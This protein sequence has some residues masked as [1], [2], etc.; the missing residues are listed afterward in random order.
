MII[1]RKLFVFHYF[2]LKFIRVLK[3]ALPLKVIIRFFELCTIKFLR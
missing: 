2:H 1:L 3:G